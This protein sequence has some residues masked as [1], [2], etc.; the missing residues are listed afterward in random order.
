M[1][2][3]LQIA[4]GT[5][6]HVMSRDITQCHDRT[7]PKLSQRP[8]SRRIVQSG[9]PR[10]VHYHREAS[11]LLAVTTICVRPICHRSRAMVSRDEVIGPVY[12]Q[13]ERLL[14]A[15]LRKQTLPSAFRATENR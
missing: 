10:L 2:V 8:L 6:Y 12:L 1:R 9:R 14:V 15:L 13:R 5:C 3:E 7:V 11:A 4:T